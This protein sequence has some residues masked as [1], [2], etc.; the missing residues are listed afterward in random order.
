M[1]VAFQIE[2]GVSL[3]C[4]ADYMP[5]GASKSAPAAPNHT[6]SAGKDASC[7]S[8]PILRAN[9]S[10]LGRT[11]RRKCPTHDVWHVVCTFHMFPRSE[12]LLPSERNLGWNLPDCHEGV[13][14]GTGIEAKRHHNHQLD[15]NA[16][17]CHGGCLPVDWRVGGI[18]GARLGKTSGRGHGSFH[19]SAASYSRAAVRCGTTENADH[20]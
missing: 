14:N 20:G 16:N 4:T 18:S 8:L 12:R 11:T 5:W 7:C 17:L 3:S 15:G 10:R 1:Q 2:T 9:L 13:V 6:R 19:R